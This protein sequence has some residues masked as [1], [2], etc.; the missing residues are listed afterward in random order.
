MAG[1]GDARGRPKLLTLVRM[2]C[3]CPAAFR[4]DVRRVYGL[5]PDD[6]WSGRVRPAAFADMAANLP[7]GSM[8]WRALDEPMAWTIADHLLAAH[9]D[10]MNRWMWMNADPKRRGR[11]PEPVPRP[12]MRGRADDDGSHRVRRISVRAVTPAELHEFMDRDFVDRDVRENRPMR[13][14]GDDKEE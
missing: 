9:V 10:Q 13:T 6:L 1:R 2:L 12:G 14:G 5:D 7:D 11:P 4:A 3:D 8:T